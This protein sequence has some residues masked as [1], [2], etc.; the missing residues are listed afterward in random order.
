[1]S[2]LST[3]STSRTQLAS[4]IDLVRRGLLRPVVT[5]RFPLAEAPRVHRL[6]VERKLSGRVLLIP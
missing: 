3:T 5:E 1:V 2:L 6:M 4:V